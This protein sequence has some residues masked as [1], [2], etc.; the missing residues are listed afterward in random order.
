MKSLAAP[1]RIATLTLALASCAS[2]PHGANVIAGP[3]KP[4]VTTAEAAAGAAAPAA[5]SAETAN[6]WTSLERKTVELSFIALA[7]CWN[8]EPDKVAG[9]VSSLVGAELPREEIVW[10]PAVHMPDSDGAKALDGHSDAL[11][12]ISRDRGSGDYSVVFR[13]TNTISATEWYFQDFKV[14]NK[15]AW[16]EVETGFASEGVASEGALVSEGT[17]TAMRLRLGLKPAQGQ[18]GEGQSL[19]EALVSIVAAS[20]GPCVMHFTGHSLGGLLAPAMALW[21]LDDLGQ[22]GREDLA[23]KLR[24][25][26]YAYAGPTAGNRAFADYLSARLPGLR[27]YASPLDIAPRV[28]E[29][30]SMASIPGLYKPEIYMDLVTKSLYELCARLSR[31]GDYAQPGAAIVVPSRIVPTRGSLFLLEAAWQHAMPYLNMLEPDRRDEILREVFEPLAAHVSVKGLKP[32]DLEDLFRAEA[33]G[34]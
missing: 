31:G 4:A 10:G 8:K 28:W 24:L 33:G 34:H 5:P 7:G 25:D 12:F 23:A 30:S 22:R 17:A 14:E 16:R 27:R 21:L 19:E 2:T 29:D 15:V 13:G 9:A 6:R 11:V 3:V 26:V 18:P 1:F 32:I 20:K